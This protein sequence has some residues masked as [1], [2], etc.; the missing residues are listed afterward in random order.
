[1]NFP[2][3]NFECSLPN[4]LSKFTTIIAMGFS[5]PRYNEKARS[6]RSAP[7]EEQNR[8]AHEY[9]GV[10]AIVDYEELGSNSKRIVSATNQDT[11]DRGSMS[12]KKRKRFD[13]FVQKKL[14]KERRIELI[15]ELEKSTSSVKDPSAFISTAHLCSS[16]VARTQRELKAT[17]SEVESR[18]RERA[19]GL[20]STKQRL[21]S[22]Y[23]SQSD[24]EDEPDSTPATNPFSGAV[25]IC[26]VSSRPN[27]T[28][29]ES[30]G[31]SSKP[32]GLSKP[33]KIVP[34]KVA[35]GSALASG[36]ITTHVK[37]HV[38]KKRKFDKAPAVSDDD[39]DSFDDSESSTHSASSATDEESQA[40]TSSESG[41]SAW[42]DEEE[43]T[44]CD[45]SLQVEE[46][47]IDTDAL[48]N[49]PQSN[50]P[51]QNA[52]RVKG[53]IRDWA[54]KQLQLA[55]ENKLGETDNEN[56]E[57]QNSSTPPQ[58]TPVPR[59]PQSSTTEST[60]AQQTR[61]GPL[62][63]PLDL[64]ETPLF[65]YQK[66]SHVSLE[67]DEE[68]IATRSLLPVFAEEHTVMD[69]I[70]RHPV[71]VICGETG[72]GKTTQV[73]QFM[74][75]AGWGKADGDNP[76]IIGVT[77]PR[78]VAA[79][80]MARRVEKEMG[81]SGKGVVSHQ[82]RYDTTTSSTT[83]IKFMTD[84]VILRE[85]AA[86]FLLSKYSVVIVDEAHERSINTD[87]LIGVLSRIVRLRL[88][89]WM[90]NLSKK[91][92]A[93]DEAEKKP[94]PAIKADIC[95]RP[96]RLIIM[97][98]TLRV[99]DFTLNSSLFSEPPPVIEIAA[100]QF[101]VAVHFMRRTPMDYVQEAFTKAAKI[102]ARLPPG[103]ILIFLT[104]QLEITKLCRKLEQKFGKKTV[105]ERKA[106]KAALKSKS[107]TYPC[108]Q[109]SPSSSGARDT[110]NQVDTTQEPILQ[111]EGFS[112]G[113]AE[114][115]SLGKDKHEFAADVDEGQEW[116]E[117]PEALD[118]DEED[119]LVVEGVE[120]VED[121][122]VPMHI[123]P[124][125]SLLP[126]DQQMKVFEEP[127]P[128]TRLVVVATNVAETSLTIPNIRYVI[129]SG[130]AKERHYDLST[131]IQSFEIDWISKASASQRAGR[132]GRTAPGHCYRLY[133]SAVF[134]NYFPQFA[135][136]EI[137]RMPI[138]GIVLQMKSMNI[139]T[140]T[141]FPFPT[142]PDRFALRKSEIS[143][144]HL[145]AL[146]FPQSQNDWFI[147]GDP[148]GE[149][150]ITDL[151]RAMAKYPLSPRFARMLVSGFQ[152][153]CLAYVI[154][155]VS[156]LSVGDP[157]IHESAI[158]E[159]N[160]A[161]CLEEQAMNET[162]LLKN[163]DYKDREIRKQKRRQFF[164]VQQV[165]SSLGGGV[166][167][168]FRVLAVVGAYE[169]G[170]GNN[171]TKFCHENFV[172]PKAMEEIHKLRA[173]ITRIVQAATIGTGLK[174][175]FSP[176][177][178]PPSETQLKVLR[179]LITSAFID[180]VAIKASKV[181]SCQ[182]SA[183]KFIANNPNRNL[184]AYRAIGIEEDVF[185]HP[186][187][188]LFD[189]NVHPEPEFIV[190]QE[191]HRTEKRIWIKGITL[192][193]PAWLPILGKSLCSFSKPIENPVNSK[194]PSR[195]NDEERKCFVIPKFGG[196]ALDVELGPVQ[197]TQRKVGN[198]WVWV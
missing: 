17:I 67:R 38:K 47:L 35:I 49:P 196:P 77:Q 48:Q 89:T 148:G 163:A 186:S 69:A 9:S 198:L 185:I 102:H 70:R 23:H 32:S 93:Q 167:D 195:G 126:T 136:P 41:S 158:D 31:H 34:H 118:T 39:D 120:L 63:V 50:S 79:V 56:P 36:A 100:R 162:E 145:G 26:T 42:L 187:S 156:I 166:S 65:L 146:S 64:P 106:R 154:A 190:F 105:E 197:M 140:V 25:E 98:A 192:I 135:K 6:H 61:C 71:V 44:G 53:S 20:I 10:E 91:E 150:T 151:G 40:G 180:Q 96:L 110:G 113:E 144:A 134:E 121:S 160:P 155:M 109:P 159:D 143:L 174:V 169:F 83:K 74:Y 73:P 33:E 115:I 85:L 75:E 14:K 84:G 43:W 157:F 141:K 15:Q 108:S 59:V 37:R 2:F 103:G 173:Q 76:G 22:G 81:L 165:F 124:L 30:D 129:D 178:M 161:D 125:Y 107:F 111:M 13:A 66:T 5:R 82:I 139:D 19:Q 168:L 132:A 133:S 116:E 114:T 58:T 92:S 152:H 128:G 4:S 21:R 29:T 188:V 90:E 94:N 175:E 170:Q 97:S 16:S 189:S 193:N 137:Q 28:T 55:E 51:S 68:V 72:S 57:V 95:C 179:Q 1:M 86:D 127:P 99:S 46:V 122:D 3:Q 80:S 177:L 27:L 172:R 182:S 101:P 104:G 52:P 171:P 147:R 149:G 24:V 194:I 60:K 183:G 87:V 138:D 8:T 62:G 117:D 78:R 88:K 11:E 12:K 191:L 112:S 130:R 164:K 131:G 7:Q 119:D 153:D 184:I 123:L 18:R 181:K 176:K 54:N 45:N 142:P